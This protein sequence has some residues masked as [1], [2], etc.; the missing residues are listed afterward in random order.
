MLMFIIGLLILV[1]HG[2]A[3]F[4]I[5]TKKEAHKVK[6]TILLVSL[7]EES[8]KTV[9][10]FSQ[11]PEEL[12]NYRSQIAGRNHAL[13]NAVEKYWWFSNKVEYVIES[14]A[15]KMLKAQKG[16]YVLIGFG[17]YLDYEKL[18]T[19]IGRDGNPAG[20]SHNVKVQ[21]KM[22]GAA[23]FT[24]KDLGMTY[25]KSTKY[26]SLANEITTLEITDPGNIIKAYLPNV[27]P[28][29]SDA[30][31]GI[32]QLQY[33]LNYLVDNEENS[34]LKL[35]GQVKKNASE[36]KRKTLIIDKEDLDAKLTEAEIKEAYPYPIKIVS[37]DEI[38]RAIFEKDSNVVYVQIT[39][40]PVG[41]GKVSAHYLSNPFNGK[42]YCVELP[43]VAVVAEGNSII[44]YGQRIKAKHLK[45]YTNHIE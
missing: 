7:S 31:Y 12:E 19:G 28:S 10:K 43:P 34:I 15:R 45:N 24:P 17:Q 20:W 38:D 27:F 6:N 11:N 9:E 33:I 25:N 4:S 39:D 3:Q 14:K 13:K 32:Q 40:A 23:S 26:S 1:N 5:T 42:I 21:D 8:P 2:N 16:K 41:K 22:P 30:V 18:N 35:P 36:L 37:Q 44:T 29:E